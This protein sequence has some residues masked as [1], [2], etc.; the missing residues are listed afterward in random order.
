MV[1]VLISGTLQTEQGSVEHGTT[2]VSNRFEDQLNIYINTKRLVIMSAKVF[3]QQT[4]EP[5]LFQ[6]ILSLRTRKID[7]ELHPF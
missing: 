4:N 1:Q 2:R 6:A 7:K 5:K 3:I